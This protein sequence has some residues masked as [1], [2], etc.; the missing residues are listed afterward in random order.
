MTF[1]SK[2]IARRWM[3]AWA[4]AVLALALSTCSG[5]DPVDPS[6]TAA[7]TG[8][9]STG[10]GGGGQ[11]GNGGGGG[12]GDGG[13]SQACE[14]G[15]SGLTL[16]PI[17]AALR[18]NPDEAMLT[19]AAQA[20]WPIA[21]PEGYLFVSTDPALTLLAGDHDGWTGTPMTADQGFHWLVLPSAVPGGHYKF[22][23]LTTWAADRWSRS[24]TY[25]EFGEMSLIAPCEAHLDRHF[26]I[27]DAQM[28]PRTVR[29]WVPEG[30]VERVLYAHDGQNLYDPGAP[31]GYWNLQASAL[32]GVLIVGI[33]NTPARMDEYTHVEDDIGEP[34]DP[35]ILGGKGDAYADFLEGTVRPLIQQR[36][37]EPGPLGLMGSSLGGLIS[38]HVADRY[39]GTYAFAASLSGTMGWGSI[40]AATHNETMIERYATHTA[41]AAV[42]YL[43]SGGV[44]EACVDSDGDGIEDDNPGDNDNYCETLQMRDTLIAAGAYEEGTTLHYW[45][46][47]GAGHNEAAWSARVF[48]PLEIFAGL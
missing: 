21:L 34:G 31:F 40:G 2:L 43:D 44:V 3:L 9:Q 46:E 16:D 29:V 47:L 32:P 27:G 23:D 30:P 11:G 12:G 14:G 42:V 38:L 41:P 17:L 48:R 45:H 15:D 39:P 8:T 7:T 35:T 24:Y 19:Y 25:D 20:G 13:G 26:E 1:R 10:T 36:Y 28:A 18:A 5:D 37:G 33:D 4:P 6:S 22:T